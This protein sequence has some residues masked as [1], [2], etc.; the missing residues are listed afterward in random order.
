MTLDNSMVAAWNNLGIILQE[1]GKLEDSLSCLERVLA[2]QPDNESEYLLTHKWGR[3][4]GAQ[5][6]S[7]R[8]R[9]RLREIGE[10]DYTTHGLRKN[11]GIYLA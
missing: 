4:Y 11:A 10:P 2:L 5:S 1:A 6:L 8:I 7:L 9:E 3:A